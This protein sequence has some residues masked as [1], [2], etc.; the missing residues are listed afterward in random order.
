MNKNVSS[1]LMVSTT[2][3]G[4]NLI[5]RLNYKHGPLFQ[6][7]LLETVTIKINFIH[8]SVTRYCIMYNLTITINRDW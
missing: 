8:E 7:Q 1:Q 5:F 4:G 2:N 6:N 3:N